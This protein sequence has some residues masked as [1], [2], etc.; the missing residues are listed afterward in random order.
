MFCFLFL[1]ILAIGSVVVPQNFKDWEPQT[2][3]AFY[4]GNVGKE[5]HYAST[6]A[7]ILKILDILV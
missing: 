6:L 1:G 3:V 2:M 4:S 5:E 7:A